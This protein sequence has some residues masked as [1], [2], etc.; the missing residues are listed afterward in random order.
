MPLFL[1]IYFTYSYR[2]NMEVDEEKIDTYD[3]SVKVCLWFCRLVLVLKLGCIGAF[4]M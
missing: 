3:I 1:D 4:L 2:Y